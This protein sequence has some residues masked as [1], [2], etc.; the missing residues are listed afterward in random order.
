MPG[1]TSSSP[2]AVSSATTLWAVLGLILSPTLSARTEGNGAPGRN[3]PK[4]WPSCRVDD[5][6]VNRDARAERKPERNHE[7]TITDRTLECK[8]ICDTNLWDSGGGRWRAGPA[9]CAAPAGL[10]PHK[11]Y[12]AAGTSL[13]TAS[14]TPLMKA[15]DSSEEKRRASS[16]ASSITTAAGVPTA[17]HLIDRQPQDVAIHD[18]HALQAPVLGVPGDPL[19]DPSHGL[20]RAADKLLHEGIGNGRRLVL[21]GRVAGTRRMPAMASSGGCCRMSARNSTCSARSRD[22]WREGMPLDS[23][24]RRG[25]AA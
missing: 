6:L 24:R 7:C 17:G 13:R 16:S 12:S 20:D 1:V 5:L 10:S 9:R 11:D 15:T 3:T 23:G 8:R 19:V 14:S 25:A 21:L 22:L 2:S 18:G 4:R